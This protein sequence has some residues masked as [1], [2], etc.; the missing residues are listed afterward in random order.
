MGCGSAFAFV[1]VLVI[2]SDLFKSKYFATM[3]GVTQ[4]LAA[5]GAM[6]GQMPIGLL[7]SSIGWR[8]TMFVLS[9]IGVA[10][11]FAS[12]YLVNYSKTKQPVE[13]VISTTIRA[14]L[15]LIMSKP[16]TWYVAL[17]ACLLWAPMSGFASLW[18]VPFLTAMDN[19]SQSEAAFLSSFMW[20]G[21]AIASPLLGMIATN[22]KNKAY[23]LAI[24]A[25]IGVASFALLLE[26]HFSSFVLGLL[27]LCAGASCAG[28]S[29]SFAVIKENNAAS[30]KATAIAFNNMAVVISGAIFQPLIGRLISLNTSTG[31]ISYNISDFKHGLTVILFAYVASFFIALFFIKE[32]NFKEL[33]TIS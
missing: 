2:T 15:K 25:L 9:F 17:Y 24:S 8:H 26:F 4:M 6:S 10:L 22:V 18:G 5:L 14:N 33:H 7:L 23:P 28:Q 12:W 13:P 21:L 27:L 16:Q 32:R 29:L 3:V 31:N 1:S 11:T 30:I 20:L 19:L